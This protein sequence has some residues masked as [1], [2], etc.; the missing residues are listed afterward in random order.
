MTNEDVDDERE[1]RS[2][3][4]PDEDISEC[5][6][7]ANGRCVETLVEGTDDGCDTV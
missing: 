2:S 5:V 7:E 3:R 4:S 6:W 1:P